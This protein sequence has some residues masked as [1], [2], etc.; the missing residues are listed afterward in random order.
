M[1]LADWTTQSTIKH[2][3]TLPVSGRIVPIIIIK[4]DLNL[5]MILILPNRHYSAMPEMWICLGH[6]HN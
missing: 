5:L 3:K 6:I 1:T 4:T 2:F